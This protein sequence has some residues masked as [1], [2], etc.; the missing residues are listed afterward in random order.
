MIKALA[1][2]DGKPAVILG[3]VEGNVERLKKGMPIRVHLKDMGLPDIDV[4]VAYGKEEGDLVAQLMP[5]MG[6]NTEVR[7]LSDPE[8]D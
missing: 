8:E 1:H 3:I 6:P 7:P 5:F 2:V 4:I